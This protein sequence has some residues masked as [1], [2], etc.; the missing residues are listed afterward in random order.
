MARI[1]A[2]EHLTL[3]GVFQAPARADEDTRNGFQHGG[4]GIAGSDPQMQEVIG[5][6]MAGGWSLLAGRTTYEDLY[7]GWVVRQ[8]ASPMTKALTGAQKFVAS[9]DAAY[10]ARWENSTLL[11][12]D[13][14]EA[15]RKLKQD[16]D[17]TLVMFGSGKLLRALMRHRLVDELV[18]MVHPLV[19]GAGSRLFEA[20][21]APSALKLSSQIATT[22]GVAILT[23]AFDGKDAAERPE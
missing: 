2:I 22:T 23:Y 9:H 20:G 14:A 17:R 19:L 4:W 16:H 12:G 21:Q 18:L 15:V 10:Q 3:D 13:A 11:A 6:A 5:R 7:E 1:V 8:P